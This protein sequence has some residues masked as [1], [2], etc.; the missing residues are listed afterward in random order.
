MKLAVCAVLLVATAAHA[1]G[2]DR[3]YAEEPTGGMFLPAQPLAGEVDALTTVVNPGGL[4]LL[5]SMGDHFLI[6]MSARSRP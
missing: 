4:P 1:Q 5:R 6:V 3:R 2:V